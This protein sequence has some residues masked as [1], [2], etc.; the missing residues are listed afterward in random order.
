[1]CSILD[2]L[3]PSCIKGIDQYKQLITYVDDRAG[4]DTRYA[5]D[6]TKMALKLNWMPKETF[7]TGKDKQ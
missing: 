5:I 2:E 4:H 3:V 6:A 7:Q 1:M